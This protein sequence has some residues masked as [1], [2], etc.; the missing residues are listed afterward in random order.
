MSVDYYALLTKAV[1][2]KDAAAREKIYKDAYDLIRNSP[3]TREVASSHVTALEDAV[4]LIESDLAAA[5]VRSPAEINT[6]LSAGRNRKPLIFGLSA[7]VAV[8][9]VSGL[10]YGYLATK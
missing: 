2:G 1:A 5:E 10:L 3:V 4:R 9:V 8:I 6:V 7:V